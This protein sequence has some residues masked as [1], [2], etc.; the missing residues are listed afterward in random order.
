VGDLRW[1]KPA[2]PL[3]QDGIQ[4]GSVGNKC[5]AAA[6]KGLN[7]FGGASDTT[8]GAA[9]D[10][11]IGPLA[12]AFQTG[13]SEDCLFL[14]LYV[15][16]SAIRNPSSAN[17]PI[18]QW[19]YGGG[20]I[21]GAKDQAQPLLPF[22]SGKPLVANSGG[23]VIFVAANYRLGAFGFLAGT[24]VEEQGMPNAGLW[25]QRAAMQ[26]VQDNIYLVGG[27][28]A[29]VTIM[30]ESAGAGSIMHHLVAEGGTLQPLFKRAIMQSPAFSPMFDRKGLLQDTYT[31][32]E[33]AVGCAGQGL[34]CLRKADSATLIAANVA[35]NANAS[36]GAFVVGPSADGKF[37]RQ[38]PALEFASGNYYKNLDSVILTHV[39]DESTVFVDGSITTDAQL[40]GYL[41]AMFP[42]VS[43]SH[44]QPK[45]QANK[46]TVR[47]G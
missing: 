38:V 27:N 24:T 6:I 21:F 8:V 34:A 9:I 43:Q 18:V 40:S 39:A 45:N 37:I 33:A 41:Q 15:P 4:D 20:Y 44:L 47:Q 1:A 5:P 3:K 35:L 13:G 22:Y 17:L 12:A 25:D 14:D 36:A 42:G 10:Q 2:P 28:P 46:N 31:T 32:F 7:L 29:E 11:L 16:G 26:W 23:N 19:I 30:G